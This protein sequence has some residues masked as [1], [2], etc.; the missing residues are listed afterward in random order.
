MNHRRPAKQEVDQYRLSARAFTLIEVLLALLL[1]AGLLTAVSRITVQTLAAERRAQTRSREQAAQAWPFETLT[2]DLAGRLR[3]TRAVAVRLDPAGRPEL[4][5]DCLLAERSIGAAQ[6]MLPHRVVHQLRRTDDGDALQWVRVAE[7]HTQRQ[8][9]T[10]DVLA[11]PLEDL[12]LEVFAGGT[13]R[14]VQRDD[15]RA[16][17]VPQALRL[18]VRWRGS[19]DVVSRT[20]ELDHARKQERRRVR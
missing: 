13:W 9:A 10:E 4:T 6:V 3:G 19:S 5:I 7:S 17:H 8:S 11:C 20:F 14:P 15:E 1:A 16:E 2:R 18:T 12:S